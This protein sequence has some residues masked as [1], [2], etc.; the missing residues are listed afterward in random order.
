MPFVSRS[1][2]PIAT[3]AVAAILVAGACT[4]PVPAKSA[5]ATLAPTPSITAAPSGAH[6][7]PVGSRD[8]W[9]VVGR[10][11][12]DDL[13]VIRASTHEQIYRLPAGV[14]D[15]VWAT[16]VA[17]TPG[18]GSTLVKELEVET[19]PPGRS[20]AIEGAWHLPTIGDD[21][22]PVGVSTDGQTIVLVEADPYADDGV[23][24]FAVLSRTFDQEPRIIEL[25][26]SF[27]YD[28]I[29]PDGSTLYVVEHLPGPPDGHYQ[30]RAVD[31]AIGALRDGVIV[32]KLGAGEAMAG[33]PIA[34]LRRSNGFVFTLY[35]GAEHPFIHA[36]SSTDAWAICIDLPSTGADDPDAAVDWGLAQS[37]RRRAVFAVNATL[38]FAVEVD[39]DDLSVRRTV[40]FDAPTSAAISLAKFGHDKSGPAGRRVVSSPDDS[41]LY[42]AGSGGIV[43]LRA[44]DLTVTD[45]YLPGAAIDGLGLTPDGR[46]LY[47]LVHE[48]GRIVEID[49]VSGEVTRRVPGDGY[50]RL[51]AVVPW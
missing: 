45:T 2:A 19:E 50:D 21:P 25:A 40:R 35:R 15:E 23:S 7:K 4:S 51:L 46:T 39:P 24:R 20:Q 5:P 36:L 9:L 41:T 48:G 22:L 3:L 27:E 31:L 34:Q 1:I 44:D 42:A 43:Q 12:E 32:D 18:N 10:A 33:W 14:P 38:G 13:Q 6:Y 11:G 37:P 17:A 49:T 8:A 29:S 28:T 26:G 47:A 16:M 30:V